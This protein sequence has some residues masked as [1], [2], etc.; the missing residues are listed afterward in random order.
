MIT[1]FTR[2]NYFCVW[3]ICFPSINLQSRKSC[4]WAIAGDS[5]IYTSRSLIHFLKMEFLL[6]SCLPLTQSSFLRKEILY[7]LFLVAIIKLDIVSLLLQQYLSFLPVCGLPAGRNCFVSFV[8]LN[9]FME[10]T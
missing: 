7:F 1:K 3:Y 10:V 2:S 9:H 8:F 6:H 4:K 5:L